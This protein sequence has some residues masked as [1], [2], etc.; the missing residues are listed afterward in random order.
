M[1]YYYEVVEVVTTDEWLAWYYGLDG[2]A[3]QAV[4]RS[5]DALEILG[6]TLGY[7]RSSEIKGTSFALREL[8]HQTRRAVGRCEPSTASTRAEMPCS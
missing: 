4:R 7:P 2:Q 6:L 3:A 1:S 8:R 5:V